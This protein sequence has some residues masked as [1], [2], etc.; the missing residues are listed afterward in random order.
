MYACQRD[1]PI[2]SQKT[3]IED[4]QSLSLVVLTI[5]KNI[6]I[7]ISYNFAKFKGHTVEYFLQRGVQ[8][9]DIQI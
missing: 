1:S 4:S 3:E 2:M 6:G 7:C 9:N 8:V 5:M